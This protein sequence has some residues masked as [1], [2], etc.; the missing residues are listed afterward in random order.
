MKKATKNLSI[1]LALFT[2]IAITTSC[3]KEGT[4]D[5][6]DS[7]L[8]TAGN[9]EQGESVSDEAGNIADAAYKGTSLFGKYSSETSSLDALGNC[10]T[11]TADTIASP[12]TLVIDFGTTNCTGNDGRTRRGKIMVTYTGKYFE[13]GSVKTMT[14][15]NFYRNDNKVEGTRTITNLGLNASGHPNWSVVATNMKITK[16][17]G[18]THTW[19]STR[20]REMVAGFDTEAYLD[21]AYLITGSA[22]GTNVK[23][24]TYTANIT[25]PLHRSLSCRCIDSGIIE[26][27][28][29]NGAARTIDFGNGTCDN[30]AVVTLTGKRGRTI[31]KTIT[32]N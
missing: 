3:N 7:E 11:I 13:A 24:R 15:D 25:T 9:S 14:F 17:D 6:A 20:N 22:N 4:D 5:A 31:T 10:A 28:R 19:N 8:T 16:S 26:F 1:L 12:H 30:E 29:S 23:G 2:I 18:N 32:L 27:T 21:D